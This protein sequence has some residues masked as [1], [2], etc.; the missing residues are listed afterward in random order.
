[1]I[2]Q[3][4]AYNEDIYLIKDK[5]TIILS[6]EWKDVSE[7]VLGGGGLRSCRFRSKFLC[8]WKARGRGNTVDV[9]LE[10]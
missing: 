10:I 8:V 2:D 6:K 9:L 1:M 7:A 3:Q 4:T 5:T